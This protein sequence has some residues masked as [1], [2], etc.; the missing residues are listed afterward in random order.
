MKKVFWPRFKDELL[1]F[2][3]TRGEG[4]S[5]MPF[6]SLNLA[7][8]VGDDPDKVVQNRFKLFNSVGFT[9]ENTI[10]VKQFHSDISLEAHNSQAGSGFADF[11]SG[12][13]ADALY[14]SQKGLALGV[15]HADCVPVFI[16]VPHLKVTGIIHAG[17]KGS[18]SS[19]T[20]KMISK[21]K[22]QYGIKGEDIFAF[23]GPSL[24]FGH[25][26]ISEKRALE[27]LKEHPN[28]NYAVKATVPEYFLDLPFLNFMQLVEQGIPSRNIDIFDDCT[29]ENDHDFFS[30]AREKT[31]GRLMSF[32]QII[33]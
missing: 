30:Y 14:T 2:T 13:N 9:K 22:N 17:E 3:S 32:V 28:F 4:Y 19:I 1:A 24:K 6:N 12:L 23:I 25:R 5:S 8:H 29:Y 16:Y 26:Q 27:I 33:S 10:I 18:L 20:A 11:E 7:F 31:T 15:Y 21:I